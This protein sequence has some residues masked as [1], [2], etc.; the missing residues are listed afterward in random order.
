MKED[1]KNII[2]NL[3]HGQSYQTLCDPVDC[4]PHTSSLQGIFQARILEWVAISSSRGSPDPGIEPPS[5]V[6]PELAGGFFTIEPSGKPQNLLNVN[7]ILCS[8]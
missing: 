8:H 6:S 2:Q 4:S 3:L 7:L 1:F 5:L